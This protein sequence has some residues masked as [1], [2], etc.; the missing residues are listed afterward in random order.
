MPIKNMAI[1]FENLA[2][3]NKAPERYRDAADIVRR[4]MAAEPLMTGGHKRFC[5]DLNDCSGKVT[6][7]GGAEGVYCMGLVGKN[8]GIAMKMDDG[9]HRGWVALAVQV[10]KD[11]GMLTSAE[12]EHLYKE[13]LK[14]LAKNTRGDIIVNPFTYFKAKKIKR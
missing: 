2:N 12:Y 3:P 13:H 8:V 9:S 1:A 11:L 10:L 14:A 4:A 5:T 6:A 7:K